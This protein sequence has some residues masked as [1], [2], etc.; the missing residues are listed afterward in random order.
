MSIEAGSLAGGTALGRRAG[1]NEVNR[2]AGDPGRK[3]TAQPAAVSVPLPALT[4]ELRPL[5][6]GQC[7]VSAAPASRG[8]AR[9]LSC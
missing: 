4:S 5:T 9:T 7:R 2:T 3:T 8:Q 1:E 6:S